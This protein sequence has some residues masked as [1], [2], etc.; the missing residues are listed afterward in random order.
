MTGI[1]E[2]ILRF[3]ALPPAEGG[4]WSVDPLFEG[5]AYLSRD[6]GG[7]YTMFLLGGR[8]SFG[9][10]PRLRGIQFVD[11]VKPVPGGTPFSG[12]K[13]TS[14][15]IDHGNRA[16]AHVA[17]EVERRL[18]TGAGSSNAQLVEDVAWILELL[19]S[20]ITLMSAEEQKGLIG[21]LLLLR[22]LVTHATEEDLPLSEAVFRWWGWDRA[23]RDF[24]CTGI[25]VE[26]KTTSSSSRRHL[27]GSLAQ[28]EPQGDE[29][30][31]VFSLGAHLDSTA[32]RKLP[33]IIAELRALLASDERAQ[34]LFDEAV[35]KYGFDE[36]LAS[37]YRAMPGV[38]NFHL[39]PKFFRASQ[40]DCLRLSSFK[41]DA[42]PTMVDEVMYILDIKSP[43]LSPEEEKAL[44]HS[45][46]TL[47]S[48]AR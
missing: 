38:L 11:G 43:E 28:L 39:P 10:F 23:K 13:L 42:L 16:I 40:L 24:A 9:T 33:D 30:V 47:P 3:N 17:Y 37:Q 8:D 26:V 48:L 14:P 15:N 27:V 25:A 32:P 46:L 21:E 36:S 20:E 2:L 45:L 34:K 18:T 5:R 7:R 41:N 1:E 22:K 44:L 6:E 4:R 29:Q 19:A 35:A 31:Y 12:L